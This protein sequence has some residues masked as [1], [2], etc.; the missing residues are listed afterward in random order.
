M[1]ESGLL[2]SFR[3]RSFSFV[4]ELSRPERLLR[5]RRKVDLSEVDAGLCSSLNPA[6]TFQAKQKGD[7]ATRSVHVALFL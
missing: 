5:A 7:S 1:S 3:E 2:K 6:S 4:P